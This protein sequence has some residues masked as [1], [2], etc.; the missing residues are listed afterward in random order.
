M[1]VALVAA[2]V[3]RHPEKATTAKANWQSYR[4][5]LERQAS[6]VAEVDFESLKRQF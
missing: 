2:F 1:I 4:E 5:L 6:T 3:A